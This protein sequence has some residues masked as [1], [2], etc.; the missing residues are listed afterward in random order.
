MAG[1][2]S[3]TSRTSGSSGST[4]T[5][6]VSVKDLTE[7]TAGKGVLWDIVIAGDSYNTTYHSGDTGAG[8]PIGPDL[9]VVIMLAGLGLVCAFLYFLRA[10]RG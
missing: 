8:G 10:R 2:T 9:D 3:A 6:I 7:N 5:G 1:S 4:A